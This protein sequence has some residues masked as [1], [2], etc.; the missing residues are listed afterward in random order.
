MFNNDFSTYGPH[1]ARLNLSSFAPGYRADPKKGRP[2]IVINFQRKILTEIA[3]Q[4]YG[5]PKVEEWV[6][7]FQVMFSEGVNDFTLM[8]N[9]NKET[10]VSICFFLNHCT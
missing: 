4:G 10:N 8:L 9:S 5:N 2:W 6:E 7:R 1:R 3:V